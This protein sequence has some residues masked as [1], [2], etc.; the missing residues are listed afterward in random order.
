MKINSKL[1]ALSFINGAVW[2]AS[3]FQAPKAE[4]RLSTEL[5]LA[6]FFATPSGYAEQN[7]ATMDPN[8]SGPAQANASLQKRGPKSYG[9]SA[10]R[11]LVQG[12]SLRTWTFTSSLV[13]RVN[14]LLRSDGRPLN[15][16]IDLWH[17]P[18]NTPQ[19]MAVYIEDGSLRP[20]DVV[21][22]SPKGDNT[23]AVRNTASLEYP[24]YAVVEAGIQGQ[25]SVSNNISDKNAARIIQGGALKTYTFSAAVGS[26]QLLLETDG[27][28][29]NSRL[30]L[31]QGPNNNKQVIDV[32]TEDGYNRPFYCVVKT[33]GSGNVIRIV[34]TGPMEYPLMCAVEPFEVEPGFDQASME[35]VGMPFPYL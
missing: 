18:D 7:T 22:E 12:G 34:N 16:D 14:V 33:P 6:P 28:P 10:D 9:R 32:Y 20:F 23:V 3:A 5:N 29:L 15:A 24:L 31:L 4:P 35:K 25:G 13:E 27:R 30:E 1:L 2:G 8:V 17:G 19:K 11:V 26:V 21:V